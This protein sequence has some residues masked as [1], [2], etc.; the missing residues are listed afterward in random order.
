MNR[1]KGCNIVRISQK[2]LDIL[3]YLHMGN[4][5]YENEQKILELF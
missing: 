3:L 1:A 2:C 5:K 4:M